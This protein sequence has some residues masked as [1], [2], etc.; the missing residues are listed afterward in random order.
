MIRLSIMGFPDRGEKNLTSSTSSCKNFQ[1]NMFNKTKCQNCFRTREAHAMNADDGNNKPKKVLLCGYLYI[2]PGIDFD[3]PLARSRKWQRRCFIFYEN[4]E[5]CYALDDDPNTIP[6]GSINMYQ[7]SNVFDADKLTGK[8]HSIGIVT[9]DETTY[10]RAETR[11]EKDSWYNTLAEYPEINRQEEKLRKK[12]AK[13]MGYGQALSN[14][15]QE[16]QP[17]KPRVEGTTIAVTAKPP[18]PIKSNESQAPKDN[19][20]ATQPADKLSSTTENLTS[21]GLDSNS[22]LG[23]G[24][25]GLRR[26]QSETTTNRPKRY[27]EIINTNPPSK[28]EEDSNTLHIDDSDLGRRNSAPTRKRDGSPEK[29]DSEKNKEKNRHRRLRSDGTPLSES[30]R[31]G[32]RTRYHTIDIGTPNKPENKNISD[33]ANESSQV[34]VP[35]STNSQSSTLHRNNNNVNIE[36]LQ[37]SPDTNKR[38]AETAPLATQEDLDGDLEGRPRTLSDLSS[39]SSEDLE[40]MDIPRKQRLGLKVMLDPSDSPSPSKR[41]IQRRRHAIDRRSRHTLDGS[42][43]MPIPSSDNDSESSKDGPT[44]KRSNSDPSLAES[45]DMMQRKQIAMTFPGLFHLKKGW[46]IK[47]GEAEQDFSKHWFVLCDNKLSYYK[48]SA[49]EDPKH[50]DGIIDLSKCQEARETPVSRNYGFQIKTA[51][52]VIILAAMTRGIRDNWVQAINKAL[53]TAQE[54]KAKE[55]KPSSEE[56]KPVVEEAVSRKRVSP[57]QSAVTAKDATDSVSETSAPERTSSDKKESRRGSLKGRERRSR[58]SSRELRDFKRLSST[59]LDSEDIGPSKGTNGSQQDTMS[60][61]SPVSSLK[62]SNKADLS[63]KNSSQGDTAV[64]E[65]LETEV[66]SLKTQLENVQ[67]ECVRVQQENSE[68]RALMN[69]VHREHKDNYQDLENEHTAYIT[70]ITQLA[71]KQEELSEKNEKYELQT[72]RLQMELKQAKNKAGLLE[73]QKEQLNE[74]LSS[75]TTDLEQKEE[76]CNDLQDKLQSLMSELTKANTTDDSESEKASAMIDRLN[77]RIFEMERELDE[78]KTKCTE[79]EDHVAARSKDIQTLQQKEN[80]QEPKQTAETELVHMLQMQLQEAHERLQES[81][82]DCISNEER[83]E[84]R[85]SR[86]ESKYQ[87]ERAVLE[88]RL[89]EAETTIKSLSVQQNDER[90]SPSRMS[91]SRMSFDSVVPL[92]PLPPDASV[93]EI[94]QK[95]AEREQQLMEL[96]RQLKKEVTAKSVLQEKYDDMSARSVNVAS[97]DQGVDSTVVRGLEKDLEAAR[98]EIKQITGELERERKRVEK[99]SMKNLPLKAWLNQN[100]LINSKVYTNLHKSNRKSKKKK[101]HITVEMRNK[102][103]QLKAVTSNLTSVQN[104]RKSLDTKLRD[105]EK[106]STQTENEFEKKVLGLETENEEMQK[107]FDRSEKEMKR[108]KNELRTSQASYDELELQ[109][110]QSREDIKRLEKTNA[111]QMELMGQRIQ[112]LTNKLAASER[113]V[114]DLQNM[115]QKAR[116]NMGGSSRGSPVQAAL[117]ENKLKEVESK[118]GDVENSMDNQDKQSNNLQGKIVL[119]EQQVEAREAEPMSSASERSSPLVTRESTPSPHGECIST[120]GAEPSDDTDSTS[121][122]DGGSTDTQTNPALRAKMLESKLTDTERKLKEVTRKL[123]DVTTKQLEDR[124]TNQMRRVSENKLKE[125]VKGLEKK[126]EELKRNLEKAHEKVTPSVAIHSG[127]G[128]GHNIVRSQSS[129]TYANFSPFIQEL[130]DNKFVEKEMFLQEMHTALSLLMNMYRY[131]DGTKESPKM[132][133]NVLFERN[134]IL[135]SAILFQAETSLVQH[136]SDHT[137]GAASIPAKKTCHKSPS[138][139]VYASVIPRTARL[140]RRTQSRVTLRRKTT[141]GNEG[142]GVVEEDLDDSDYCLVMPRRH[143]DPAEIGDMA[144]SPGSRNE[145]PLSSKELVELHRRWIGTVDLLKEKYE[146]VLKCVLSEKET[147]IGRIGRA[148]AKC[149]MQQ[150]LEASRDNVECRNRMNEEELGSTMG[151]II[152]G[153]DAELAV[154]A[155]EI[156]FHE[157]MSVA[158]DYVSNEIVLAEAM[159]GLHMRS[160]QLNEIIEAEAESCSKVLNHFRMNAG[161]R[162][163][164]IQKSLEDVVITTSEDVRQS[165]YDM[166]AQAG[167]DSKEFGVNESLGSLIG[168]LADMMLTIAVVD[169]I[170]NYLADEGCDVGLEKH[171]KDCLGVTDLDIMDGIPSP[172]TPSPCEFA[173]EIDL[174]DLNTEAK[175]PDGWDLSASCSNPGSSQVHGFDDLVG[176]NGDLEQALLNSEAEN[177]A[178]LL[179]DKALA[180]AEAVYITDCIQ[181]EWEKTAEAAHASVM[182]TIASEHAHNIATI[183]RRYEKMVREEQDSHTAELAS[184]QDKYTDALQRIRDMEEDLKKVVALHSN[185]P[186]ITVSMVQDINEIV[187]EMMANKMKRI[188]SDMEATRIRLKEAQLKLEIQSEDHIQEVDAIT[189]IMETMEKKY[190]EELGSLRAQYIER[191]EELEANMRTRLER[192][193]E[194]HE[195]EL[196]EV[197]RHN[198]SEIARIYEEHNAS[199]AAQVRSNGELMEQEKSHRGKLTE[200]RNSFQDQMKVLQGEKDKQLHEEA[201]ATAKV[202]ASLQEKHEQEIEQERLNLQGGINS[203]VEAVMKRHREVVS[204]MNKEWQILSQKFSQVCQENTQLSRQVETLSKSLGD[205]RQQTEQLLSL[206][207][208]LGNRLTEEVLALSKK[209]SEEREEE[210]KEGVLQVDRNDNEQITPTKVALHIREVEL[211]CANEELHTLQGKL[212]LA[213]KN[214]QESDKQRSEFAVKCQAHQDYIEALKGEVDDLQRQVQRVRTS[215]EGAAAQDDPTPEVV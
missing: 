176:E 208:E 152:G 141:L 162:F 81:E 71:E 6:Q 55:N 20:Q 135:S 155:E 58:R 1:P 62:E 13:A 65:L 175:L 127:K 188:E 133:A 43:H 148:L 167:E 189:H 136:K 68:L 28:G 12:R 214:K 94:G 27:H 186:D 11:E 103:D 83:F 153:W 150:K 33:K 70:Q 202:I 97:A 183:R 194:I 163:E 39:H 105:A 119:V 143:S 80:H 169:G 85:Y 90:M 138:E 66:E 124:K 72:Q 19:E 154:Y 203:D 67:R 36:S 190:K 178:I 9:P 101:G 206:N 139:P 17:D 96:R 168:T 22:S 157:A 164:W 191:V 131:V 121:S 108:L 145:M 21:K 130:D 215:G 161:K 111:E 116:L 144:W 146:M 209:V 122:Q 52:G 37:S 134:E 205:A 149:S 14:N 165:Y 142:S 44:L 156:A 54:D 15:K 104:E 120:S 40:R 88:E 185:K 177:V 166:M 117:I 199:M 110:I 64:M 129:E 45:N 10:I 56:N 197:V 59:S 47:Q 212:E 7:C 174:I 48:D 193:R 93:E 92:S 181:E 3:N 128:G 123:V 76:E 87:A 179:A 198:R 78:S 140:C 46:L 147:I 201:Q 196:L 51:D 207:K 115:E 118:L 113:K 82:Q 200:L 26:S 30:K 99:L 114:R 182:E 211:Q 42:M 160:K 57:V 29:V 35:A 73:Q 158:M 125:Q 151:G 23:Q 69:A 32:K 61:S 84:K 77:Q 24:N 98:S 95:L 31:S 180:H 4:G 187:E 109:A 75:S 74:R 106:A 34:G 210:D 50:L 38:P 102:E 213:L 172:R 170:I 25:I 132:S 89:E 18:E 86:L 5:L 91:P 41:T 79:L 204:Q 8:E 184:M 137:S 195:R 16:I 192:Q 159:Q 2:A 63:N 107:K 112:D 171:S 53:V 126:V 49:D 173:D 60:T 100:L